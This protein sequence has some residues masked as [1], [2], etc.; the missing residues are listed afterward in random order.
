LNDKLDHGM[1]WTI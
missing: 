1:N